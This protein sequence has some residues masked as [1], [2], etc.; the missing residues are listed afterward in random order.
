[1]GLLSGL[2]GNAGQTD[3][4]RVEAQL[5]AVLLPTEQVN[6]AFSLIRDL[7]VFTDK[8]LILVDKQGMTGKKTS[9]KS[10]PY[11]SISRFEVETSGHFD[12]DAELKIWISSSIEPAEI[13]QFKS[14]KSVI[15]IQQALAEAVLN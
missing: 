14:D 12:L 6:E 1:M 2:M 9:Y 4:T 10:I 13:L 7:I 15:A 11:R 5:E 8:R 3:A